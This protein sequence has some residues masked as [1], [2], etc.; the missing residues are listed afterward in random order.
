MAAD[1]AVL[2]NLV[3]KPVIEIWDGISFAAPKFLL[4][5]ILI[6]VGYLAGLLIGYLIQLFLQKIGFD[7]QV[8]KAKLTQIVG[9]VKMSA[10]L[11]EITK[12]FIFIAFLSQAVEKLELGIISDLLTRFA[13]W[14]PNF[15]A[16]III[17][18][19]GL[20]FVNL[21]A[22][23]IEEHS[24]VKGTRAIVRLLKLFL[25][26]AVILMGLQQ[27]QLQTGVVEKAFL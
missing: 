27:M 17:I 15:V 12:W 3:Y 2:E 6:L 7:K 18:V 5:L 13:N 19:L 16:G 22:V 11:G 20:V 25:I 14:L 8:E 23:K 24:E 21:I 1:N 26:I 9:H 4:A 10:F